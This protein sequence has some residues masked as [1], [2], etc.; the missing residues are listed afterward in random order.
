MM[1]NGAVMML[2]GAVMMLNPFVELTV[3]K[4]WH[5]IDPHT[6]G[7]ALFLSKIRPLTHQAGGLD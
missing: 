7:D 4:W 5:S 3:T 1:L 6:F 2:N